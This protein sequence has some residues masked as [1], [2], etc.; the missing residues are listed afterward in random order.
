VVLFN[1]LI[2]MA[3]TPFTNA[4]WSTTATRFCST[5]MRVCVCVCVCVC[6]FVCVCV[7]V[8][9]CVFVCVCVC[10]CVCVCVCVCMRA[11]VRSRVSGRM[12]L[13]STSGFE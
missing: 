4:S 5:L 10:L 13:R 12:E 6:V 8:C 1:S 3:G 7:C 9:V 2:E 11:H